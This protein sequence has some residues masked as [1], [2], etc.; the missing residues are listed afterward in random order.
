VERWEEVNRNWD[1]VT[2][3]SNAPE[4]SMN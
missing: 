3:F 1:S 2:R 4:E